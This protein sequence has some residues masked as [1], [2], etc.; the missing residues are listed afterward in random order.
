MQADQL[1]FD[2]RGNRVIAQ[3]SVEIYYNNYILTADEV[4]YDGAPI[5]WWPQATRSSR[6][7]TAMPRALTDSICPT[8]SGM[9]SCSHYA[10]PSQSEIAGLT[11]FKSGLLIFA[12]RTG[13]EGALREMLP[14][15]CPITEWLSTVDFPL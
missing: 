8:T 4:T 15:S 11:A 1:I 14:A 12:P 3:G 2:T 10:L 9:R 6:S 7:P 5:A 13:I